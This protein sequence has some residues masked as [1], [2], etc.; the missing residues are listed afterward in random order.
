LL[1]S[2]S[3]ATT[4]SH[5]RFSGVCFVFFTLFLHTDSA[6]A[7]TGKI[8][9]KH[10][11]ML[12]VEDKELF[13]MLLKQ[14]VCLLM[15]IAVTDGSDVLKLTDENFDTF[16]AEKQLVLVNFHTAR[17]AI[18]C[19]TYISNEHGVTRGGGDSSVFAPHHINAATRRV[20]VR[21]GYG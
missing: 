20:R 3:R 16:L 18:A 14:V 8:V 10:W 4:K 21:V 6:G 17:Y 5:V 13:V 11:R 12:L 19:S 1:I 9:C 7:R 2:Q 15:V